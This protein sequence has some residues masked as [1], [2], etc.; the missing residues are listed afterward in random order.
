[1]AVHPMVIG[2]AWNMDLPCCDVVY[3]DLMGMEMEK[4]MEK[5]TVGGKHIVG[6]AVAVDIVVVVVVAAAAV[7]AVA[8]GIVVV[9]VVVGAAKIVVNG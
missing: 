9:V 2:I 6:A 5:V 8:V 7:A 4:E 3:M 1:M